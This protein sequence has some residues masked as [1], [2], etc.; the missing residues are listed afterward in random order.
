M[1]GLQPPPSFLP[2]PGSPAIP[3]KQWK[4]LFEN[5]L[6]AS[7]ASK[8]NDDR[9]R[10]MLLHCLGPEGQRVFHTLPAT[11][12]EAAGTSASADDTPAASV[13]PCSYAETLK[14]LDSHFTPAVNV[15]A[16][17]YRFRQRGQH[18]DEP[19]D[20]YVSSLRALSVNCEFGSMRDEFIRDQLVEKTNSGRIRERLLAEPKLT[21]QSAITLARTMESAARE[22]RAL[23]A[24]DRQV[25]ALKGKKRWNSSDPRKKQNKNAS[26][27]GKTAS[28]STKPVM[29][30]CF[31]CGENGHKAND[32]RCK[33]L[34]A[35]CTA[36]K[37]VG[38]FARVCQ[39]KKVNMVSE[40]A[41][42]N[43]SDSEHVQVLNI[44]STH[45]ITCTVS[46]NDVPME[47][48]FDT[49]S[50][51]SIIPVEL[52]DRHF[53]RESL[54]P[55]RSGVQ[56]TTY[57]HEPIPI[58][59][60]FP[61]RVSHDSNTHD[62]M[63]YVV[64]RG[65]CIL[66][67]DLI[68]TLQ[69]TLQDNAVLNI[70]VSLE[71]E[72][73][74][75]FRDGVGLARGFV[76]R[77]KAKSDIQPVQHKLRRLPFALREKVSAE[78]DRMVKADI[79]EPV[80]ASEW[81][82]PLV[83]VH[84]RNGNIRLCVDLRSV[85]EA[86][87]QDKYPLPHIEEL[88]SELRGST[89]FTTLDL[90]SA[91]HQLLL[92][93]D[94]RY[95]TAFIT[96]DGLFRF[97]RVCFGLSSAPSAFQK[98]MVTVLAGLNGVQCYLDDI[99]IHGDTQESHDANLRAVLHRLQ[100]V[101][102]TLNLQKCHFN[103]H[104]IS[105]LGHVISSR[106]LQPDE[107]HVKAIRDASVP[108]DSAAL[109]SFLGLASYYAKFLPNFSTVT[110][111]LRELTKKDTPFVWSPAAN[112]AFEKI[113]ELILH[114]DTLHLFDPDLPVII[115][116]DASDHG[117]GAI[118]LQVKDGEDVP[119]AFA[120][121]TLTQAERNYSVGEKEALACVWACEKWFQYVWGRHFIL[122]TDHQALTTLL[123]AKGSKRQSMRIARW[124]TRLLRFNYTVEYVPGLHNY[125]ADALS[126]LPQ[127]A[128][129]IIEDDDQEVVIQSIFADATIS[130][131]ELQN[132][133]NSDP[134]LQKVRAKISRGWSKDDSKDDKLKAYYMV[135]DELAVV[136]D[137]IL[138]GDRLVI[139]PQFQAALIGSAH[140][141]HQG[142]VRSK[143]R[144]REL[145]WWPSMDR[146][147]EDAIRHCSACQTSD[148]VT[149]THN[150]PLQ[151]VPLP[152]GPWQ[153]IGI[154]I[155]GPFDPNKPSQKYAIVA[156]DYYSKWPEVAF[157]SEV[158][159]HTVITFLTQLFA[160]E[161]L[162]TEIVTDNGVQFVSSEFENFLKELGIS[163]CKASLYY[164]RANGEVERWNRVLK[165][166]LQIA[167]NQNKPWKEA[168]LELLM[169]YRA[170]PHQTT[171]KTPAEMLHGR[172][173]V[174]PLH[175]RHANDGKGRTQDD[176]KIR[177]R[178][179]AQQEK[180]RQYTDKVRGAS[181]PK[182]KKGDMVRVKRLKKIGGS[183]FEAPR[184][185]VGQ[186]GPYTF[187]LDDGRVWNASKLSVYKGSQDRDLSSESN[188][189]RVQTGGQRPKRQIQAPVWTR[190][191]VLY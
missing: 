126:R 112:Q 158:T 162:P 6:L 52:F 174:T 16:E 187:V 58:V 152:D 35:R 100:S 159:T 114:C 172:P 90:T 122:R 94:S 37:K 151:S 5:F 29:P 121:R 36:C 117:L 8:F 23:D 24:S 86:I 153:K 133:T 155:T 102:L 186:K 70:S 132:A 34:T 13:P 91:Y 76:H 166:T 147:V 87:V 75:L 180:A 99:I 136:D 14:R 148:K 160:R 171:G 109:R 129:D 149:R 18:H 110:A 167:T 85:N 176:E 189:T 92:H 46:I 115:S 7:G 42:N 12:E 71:N 84:K 21:L 25:N 106:G 169:A 130:K 9:R 93:E 19:V 2:T 98:L 68:T 144:L 118:L 107:T 120:S 56:L 154:D 66:G 103:L 73:P 69:L 3:W 181:E 105:Y 20:D 123:S 79:I 55:P 178:V 62:T 156:I 135:R 128:E 64:E 168:T 165:Q 15:V 81:I 146:M 48:I 183:R 80:D 51:V 137:C 185:I 139:P 97:K 44:A 104:E 11:S 77:I 173:M 96:H 43:A 63:L 108:S 188:E 67:R 170:T 164:P 116:T 33:A 49:G 41:Q 125:A 175:I 179:S 39:S 182:F 31:R 150:T 40:D 38:H 72:F 163:H 138:R 131:A 26:D 10:A 101:G 157:V 45:N 127:P 161:G 142:I 113:K 61:A 95:L 27:H 65:S 134:L 32:Q 119:V 60:M 190:D 78:L 124:A 17:R 30:V 140:A 111:P 74:E 53:L 82:S 57:L 88:L 184:R 143:Q 177:T 145:Y 47:F 59:G 141:A 4:A 1:A 54:L 28:V 50:P 191:H 22:S 83:V 89:V